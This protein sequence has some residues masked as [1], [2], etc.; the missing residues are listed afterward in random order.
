MFFGYISKYYKRG[1]K[2]EGAARRIV[3]SDFVLQYIFYE[4]R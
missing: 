1:L 4:T 3:F 2:Y